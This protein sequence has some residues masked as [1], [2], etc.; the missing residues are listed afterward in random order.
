MVYDLC[1][2]EA[3]PEQCYDVCI[4]GSGPAGGTLAHV[5]AGRGLKVCVLESGSH[6]PER[7]TDKLREVESRGMLIKEYS[8][9]RVLG[10]ASSTW[11]GLS[12][13][14]DPVDF[15][16][17]EWV[18]WSGWPVARE[19][20]IPWYREA[21]RQFR[22][23]APE[24][25]R[26]KQWME[27]GARAER[28]PQWEALQEKIFVAPEPPPDYGREFAR[29]YEG[30]GIDL[31]MHATVTRLEGSRENGRAEAA[32]VMAP[33]GK[34]F[35]VHARV[36]VLA[37]GGIENPRIL[38]NST[39]ACPGGLG[40]DRDQVGRY[41]MNH[42]KNNFGVVR[43]SAPIGEAPG[44]FGFLSLKTGHAAYVGLRVSEVLQEKEGLLNAYVRFE[45]VFN[46]SGRESIQ[47]L[48]FFVKRSKLLLR[49][50][51]GAKGKRVMPLRDYSETG[52]DSEL[53]NSRKSFGEIAGMAGK[54]SMDLPMV[55]YYV[56]NRLFDRKPLSV[57]EIWLRNFMEMAP[58]PTNRV[59]LGDKMDAFGM[60]LPVV[61]HVPGELD[62]RSMAAV[63][64][65]LGQELERSGL[66][67]LA[68][69]LE[70][71]TDPWPVDFDASH[72]M[73]ATR[74]GN[75]P[76]TSVVDRHG[77]LHFCDN[78]YMAGASVFPTS[79]SANPTYTIVAL[80]IRLGEHLKRN[81]PCHHESSN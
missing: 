75:D 25:F 15:R 79:G 38:L 39:Y 23:P 14:L 57:R 67:R 11:A 41:F 4:V 73:G 56:Y 32:S 72:H 24:L 5:L 1:G 55:M 43:L 19:E 44:Y 50:V 42:P 81:L 22:F 71:A 69:R 31:F 28:F 74:M 12:S 78:V 77:R 68:D 58:D 70:E 76:A 10:G 53:M 62:K 6:R 18:P 29:I 33:G 21:A 48:Q 52:D 51:K 30:E 35:S 49:A 60:P 61:R 45:P 7:F 34:A 3:S 27:L 36:F 40:N 64:R 13:P 63:Q 8:R 16:K 17:R 59:S 80:A 65:Y 46:W 2:M 37:C 20:L 26:D 47:A 66:G 9:E 54:I